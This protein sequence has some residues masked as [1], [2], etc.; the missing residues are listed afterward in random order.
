M[1]FAEEAGFRSRFAHEVAAAR[2]VSGVFTAAVVAADA[3]ADVPWLAGVL[4]PGAG[5]WLDSSAGF[6]ASP[7]VRRGRPSLSLPAGALEPVAGAGLEASAGFE[8][9]PRVSRGG[10]SLALLL[11]I[12]TGTSSAL[13]VLFAASVPLGK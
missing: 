7:R 5:A 12:P 3:A 10:S 2:R 11:P 13:R 8:D 9:F 4:E 6:A 1:E